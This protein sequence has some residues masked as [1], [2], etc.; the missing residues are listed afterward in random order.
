MLL[1]LLLKNFPR[2]LIA[3][4][5]KPLSASISRTVKTVS[6]RIEF[7]TFLVESVFVA[8]LKKLRELPGKDHE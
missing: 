1:S 4:T 8:T 2:I 7:P 5:R 6:Y 3:I